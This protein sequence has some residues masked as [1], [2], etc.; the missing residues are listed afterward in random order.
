MDQTFSLR[1]ILEKCYEFSVD[2]H[3]LLIEFK[4]AYGGI[5]N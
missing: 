1:T 4:Q 3:I 5:T 2:L